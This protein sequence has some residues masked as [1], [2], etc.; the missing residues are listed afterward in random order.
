M[1]KDEP[2]IDQRV[3]DQPS[4]TQIV[5]KEHIIFGEAAVNKTFLKYYTL[6]V[7]ILTGTVTVI[8]FVTDWY[9]QLG[10]AI[11]RGMIANWWIPVLIVV[12]LSLAIYINW[13]KKRKG[14][15]QEV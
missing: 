1:T 5:T 13:P 12:I 10:M 6:L 7:M 3:I 4:V 2:V 14:A 15:K 8:A 9:Y 11:V